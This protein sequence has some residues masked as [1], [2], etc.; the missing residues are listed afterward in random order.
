MGAMAV[1]PEWLN[2]EQRRVLSN[3]P[4][5]WERFW[6]RYQANGNNGREAWQYAQPACTDVDSAK[7]Q[8]CRLLSTNVNFKEW[9][10][11]RAIARM[12]ESQRWQTDTMRRSWRYR[13]RIDTTFE[14]MEPAADPAALK[15]LAQAEKTVD[16]M[17]R[18]TLGLDVPGAAVQVNLL[19][20]STAQAL[21]PLPAEEMAKLLGET[22]TEST[23][24]GGVSDAPAVEPVSPESPSDSPATS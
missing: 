11:V 7:E 9:L 3:A 17:A 16:D 22:V 6:E 1:I 19:A 13:E 10:S 18:R 21:E 24:T 15:M 14:Q 12:P 20:A 5:W 4:D 23:T 2:E 8:A